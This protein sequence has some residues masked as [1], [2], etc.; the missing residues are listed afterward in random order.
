MSAIPTE[1]IR[2]S[3]TALEL[4]TPKGVRQKFERFARR[5]PNVVA[6]V[7]AVTH[8]DEDERGLAFQ[9]ALAIDD[10]YRSAL[11][12]G[13]R[14]VTV[15]AMETAAED[16]DRSFEALTGAELELALRRVLFQHDMAAPELLVEIIGLLRDEVESEPHLAELL[17]VV[18][19]VSKALLVAY[20]RAHGIDSA[21]PKSSIGRAL[22]ARLGR[23]LPKVVPRGLC[24]CGSGAAFRRCCGRRTRVQ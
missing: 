13:A 16:T 20:E 7:S 5:Q 18:L 1:A 2:E 22:E 10:A 19:L 21:E 23:P 4:E 15:R 12:A 14:R 8:D 11:G 9:I 3:W 24:P 6:Y 17:G